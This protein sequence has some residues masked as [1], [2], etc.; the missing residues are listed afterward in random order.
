MKPVFDE[1]GACY[2]DVIKKSIGFMGRKH[3]YYTSVKADCILSFLKARGISAA[4][5]SVLDAGCGIG[6]MDQYFT[7]TFATLEGVDISC[8]SVEEA[9]RRN[10]RVTYS[11]YEEGTPFPYSDNRFDVIF[12][13]CVLHHI[14]VQ[15]R[16]SFMRECRRVLK[17]QGYL[18]IFEHN[19]LNPLTRLVVRR[20]EFD[21]GAELLPLHTSRAL[22]SRAR[23]VFCERRFIFFFPFNHL[24]F[25]RLENGLRGLPLGA[26]YYVVGQ[27]KDFEKTQR[28]DGAIYADVSACLENDYR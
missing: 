20:C 5:C 24:F 14:P 17:P 4:E 7:G 8:E 21:R 22:L 11:S 16:E 19:S 2:D 13:S 27:K 10:P 26:Q 3:D 9:R 25:K 6:L 15:Q 23:L 18:F 12:I 28:A 1:Y